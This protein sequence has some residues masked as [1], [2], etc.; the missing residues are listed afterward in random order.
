MTPPSTSSSILPSQH[1]P[2]PSLVHSPP[3]SHA[4]HSSISR[5]YP[6][7]RDSSSSLHHQASLSGIT[8]QQH[9]PIRKQSMSA[10][11]ASSS[12]HGHYSFITHDSMSAKSN[13][14]PGLSPASLDST[15]SFIS[16]VVH[17][18]VQRVSPPKMSF[19]I[20]R[21]SLLTLLVVPPQLPFNS[22]MK[23][24][25]LEDDVLIRSCV[26]TLV[27]ISQF[28]LPAVVKEVVAAMESL[29]K[30]S[31]NQLTARY[32][33]AVLLTILSN[34]TPLSSERSGILR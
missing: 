31:N 15:A 23:L 29:N 9:V 5:A 18:L 34:S 7:P 27:T 1:H 16:S 12:A 33:I 17:R 25:V 6:T 28:Q 20:S 11:P 2:Q 32:A 24:T 4:P 14:Y 22:G 21:S 3:H 30:V 19:S 8:G 26:A 10:G 13:P